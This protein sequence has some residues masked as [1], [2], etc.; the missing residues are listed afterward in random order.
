LANVPEERVTVSPV[1]PVEVTD[2]DAY[3]PPFPLEYG[4][5][6][7][8]PD[9]AVPIL[10]TPPGYVAALQLN[11]VTAPID[12]TVLVNVQLCPP[13][14]TA[15][16]AVPAAEGVPVM[17]YIALPFP[18]ASVPALKLAVNPVTPV[19]ATDCA[20]YVPPFPLVY[21]IDEDMPEAA[22]PEV[23]VPLLD[24]DPQSNV[25]TTAAGGFTGML[26]VQFCPP[27]EMAKSAFPAA[28]GVP[29]MV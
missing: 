24:A 15:K 28:E 17:V 16:L 29:V 3:T 25:V 7:D 13:S 12:N 5:T 26:R 20:A 18:L 21:G 2:W 6:A 1:T 10:G 22:V 19:E 14:E 8:I 9:A 23:K 11:D 27:S 4:I